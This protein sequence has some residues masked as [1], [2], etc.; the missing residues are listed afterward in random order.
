LPVS[1]SQVHL[2]SLAMNGLPSC[3]LTP[4]RHRKVSSVPSSLP[5][6]LNAHSG[7]IDCRLFCGTSC[8]YITRLLNTPIIGRLAAAVASSCTDM[9]A[10]LSKCDILATPPCFWADAAPATEIATSSAPAAVST[11]RSGFIATCLLFINAGL[12]ARRRNLPAHLPSSDA[13]SNER[14]RVYHVARDRCIARLPCE[15]VAESI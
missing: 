6:Q 10:G 8:L 1:R 7:T 3:H 13:G 11:R 14:C 9:L 2:T 12:L 5:D 4:W 15:R